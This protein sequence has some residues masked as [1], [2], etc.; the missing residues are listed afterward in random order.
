MTALTLNQMEATQPCGRDWNRVGRDFCL[1]WGAFR[2][3]TIPLEF[4]GVGALFCTAVDFGC[5]TASIGDRIY[6]S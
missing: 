3:A 4:T 6:N 5:L 1:G 2:F